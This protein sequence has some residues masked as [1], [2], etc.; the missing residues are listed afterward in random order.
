MNLDSIIL[1]TEGLQSAPVDDEIVFLIP[2]TDSYVALDAIGRRV[3][4]LLD[5]PRPVAEVVDALL[6][7]YEGVRD[8]VAGDVHGFLQELEREGMVRVVDRP[9]A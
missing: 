8:D 1:R 4:D 6:Q 3:W 9:L 7:E 5:Q 2:K